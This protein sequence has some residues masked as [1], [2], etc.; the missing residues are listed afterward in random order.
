MKAT[1][2]VEGRLRD[3]LRA[4]LLRRLARPILPEACAHN[5]RHPLDHRKTVLGEPNASYNRIGQ[6]VEEVD[7]KRVALPVLQSIG[8]CM[9]GAENIEAWPG[10][11]CEEPLDAQRCPYFVHRQTR[12]A[13]YESFIG[14][15]SDPAW[16]ESSLPA[17]HALLWVLGGTMRVKGA[18]HLERALEWLRRALPW[19]RRQEAQADVSVYLPTL[20]A[21]PDEDSPRALATN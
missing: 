9:L 19:A 1:L 14:E 8:L 10:N 15:L 12:E 16:V 4:E 2:E 17:V 21:C 11:I 6:D 5:Y 3:M 20:D 18:S 13:V 7:G